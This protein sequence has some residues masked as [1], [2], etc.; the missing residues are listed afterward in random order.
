MEHAATFGAHF[1]H[2][3][4]SVNE[5]VSSDG[6]GKARG[7]GEGGGLS[8]TVQSGPAVALAFRADQRFVAILLD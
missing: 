1:V 3:N 4:S 6:L 8:E 7:V 5:H 2:A